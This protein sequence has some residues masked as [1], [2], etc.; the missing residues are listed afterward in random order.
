MSVEL[1][2]LKLYYFSQVKDSSTLG[3]GEYIR[4]L[5]ED[6][7][8]DYEYVR[9][10]FAQWGEKK[11]ELS[12][13]GIPGPTMPF[14]TVGD[15][16]YGKT[17]PIIRFIAKKLGKYNGVND[18]EEQLLDAYA[19]TV[20]DWAGKW[21]AAIFSGNEE[22]I[23]TYEETHRV[24]AQSSVNSMLAS[25]EGPYIFGEKITYVDFMIYHMAD[26]DTKAVVDAKAYPHLHKLLEAI[27]SRPS[28]KK[29][30]DS[31]K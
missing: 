2:D 17:A 24:T 10:T 18:D 30:F 14:I 21:A 28:L 25:T 9:L 5:L 20:L 4:L 11:V 15:K 7:G 12:K 19:D 29:H 27:R 13:Q 3:R 16:Y 23:K 6:A 26:D 8:L 22:N 1:K 31:L